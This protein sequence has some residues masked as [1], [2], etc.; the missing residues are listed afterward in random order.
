MTRV[1]QQTMESLDA[2]FDP[3]NLVE[4]V[5]DFPADEYEPFAIR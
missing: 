4:E 5:F 2:L 1:N 3:D